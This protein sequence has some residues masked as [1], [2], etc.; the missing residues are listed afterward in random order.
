[1]APWL[2][3]LG[4]RRPFGNHAYRSL[5]PSAASGGEPA[6]VAK[7]RSQPVADSNAQRRL[8]GRVWDKKVAYP[9]AEK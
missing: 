5:R 1:M 2:G 4:K 8:I 6:S 7:V 3:L 9:Y